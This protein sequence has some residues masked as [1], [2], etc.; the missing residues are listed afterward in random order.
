MCVW[1]RESERMCVCMCVFVFTFLCLKCVCVCAF[2]RVHMCVCDVC[3]IEKFRSKIP[4]SGRDWQEGDQS[5][6]IW[7][8]FHQRSTYSFMLEDPESVKRYRW[9]NSIFFTLLGSTSVKA[10][11]KVLVK[12]TPEN[13]SGKKLKR[14]TILSNVII[15][16]IEIGQTTKRQTNKQFF[17]IIYV[18][19]L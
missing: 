13:E 12:L 2:T 16:S 11:L 15:N 8:Q 19:N 1:E 5:I 6:D 17:L 9:L 3:A 18:F 14:K 4:M 7:A 10:L